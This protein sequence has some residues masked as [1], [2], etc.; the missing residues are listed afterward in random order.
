MRVTKCSE[1]KV[2]VRW[3]KFIRKKVFYFVH[4]KRRISPAS[5]VYVLEVVQST[6]SKR[7]SLLTSCTSAVAF[8]SKGNVLRGLWFTIIK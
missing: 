8:I 2:E 7:A 3:G 6:G 1:A 5:K 4:E